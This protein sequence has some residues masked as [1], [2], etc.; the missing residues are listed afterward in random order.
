MFIEQAFTGKNNWTLYILTVLIV[1]VIM[2]IASLPLM[3]YLIF[4]NPEALQNGGLEVITDTNLGL[5][6]TLITFVA[7]FFSLLFCVKYIHRKHYLDI[8]TSRQK[9]NW[10]R[11]FF[12]AGVWG[13]LS[14]IIMLTTI[15][16]SR[17]NEVIFQFNFVDFIGLMVIS[18]LLLPFQT[19]F[20]EIM[21]RGYLMQGF[22]L[23]FK[24][25]WLSVII[26]AILFGLMHGANPEVKNF[27]AEVT[28][29]QYIIM[30]LLLGFIALKDEGLE[31]AIGLHAANNILAAITFT[32]D[33][34]ALQTHALFKDLNPSV[35]HLDTLILLIAGII[36]IAVCNRKYHF[37]H[38][39]L[40]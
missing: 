34:S 20:E 37:L 19:A 10:Q 1:F 21:F 29:P 12:G 26:V 40:K 2:Q 15:Y 3:V 11:F 28:L 25:R 33:A 30:G 16:T 8:I 6:L 35:S 32:S 17:N 18:L 4:T 9:F 13:I 7:G 24:S 22:A 38:D 27:G 5:A 36:F 23:F 31:L 14:L 39:E